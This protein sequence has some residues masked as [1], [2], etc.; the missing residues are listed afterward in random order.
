MRYPSKRPSKYLYINI[1]LLTM[2]SL[3]YILS[4][5]PRV[6]SALNTAT[7]GPL[8]RGS[9]SDA[10]ALVCAVRWDAAALPKMLS[11]CEEKG[12]PMTFFVYGEWA[13][14]NVWMLKKIREAGHE[15]G[16][17]G[18]DQ[19]GDDVEKG[20]RVIA[21]ILGTRPVLYMPPEDQPSA[22]QLKAAS[23]ADCR[24]VVCSIDALGAKSADVKLIQ[25]RVVD[26]VFGG[27]IV[28]MTPTRASAD[29][30]SGIIDGIRERQF[31]CVRASELFSSQRV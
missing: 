21:D 31:R 24:V 6:Q 3:V 27:A 7:G 22:S 12:I 23:T 26:N 4:T 18:Y 14:K 15:I 16:T 28:R 30:L 2:I 29:A 9:R 8:F 20:V 5:S 1:L 19:T 11:A 10:V 17:L 25:Q 13:E